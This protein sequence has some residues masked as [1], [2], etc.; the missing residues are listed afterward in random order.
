MNTKKAL[1]IVLLTILILLVSSIACSR[2][3]K[4]PFLA[5]TTPTLTSTPTMTPTP[6]ATS[7]PTATA[8]PPDMSVMVIQPGDLPAG[9]QP[10]SIPNNTDTQTIV[11][12]FDANK[13]QIVSEIIMFM[14]AAT[15]QLGIDMIIDNPDFVAKI[16]AEETQGSKFENVQELPDMD[17][18]GDKSKGFT[19]D[20]TLSDMKMKMDFFVMKKGS[21]TTIIA[22]MY[23]PKEKPPITIQE[24]AGLA[25]RKPGAQ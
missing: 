4:L 8:T 5:T 9:F 13:F 21:I 19:S 7:T 20:T 25:N 16:L 6:L 14:P 1:S 12:Y 3:T 22:S 24:L 11:G 23:K 2:V 17:K 18:Y 15:D 10:L